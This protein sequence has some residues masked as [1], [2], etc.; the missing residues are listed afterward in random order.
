M[1]HPPPVYLSAPDTPDS[2]QGRTMAA[3]GSFFLPGPTEVLDDVLQAQARPMIGHRGKG[4]EDL[5]ARIQPALRRVF[6]HQG[7]VGSN[8]RPFVVAHVARVRFTGGGCAVHPLILPHPQV[9]NRL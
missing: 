8:E 3:F 5:L 7:Q 2:I 6:G 9:H 1:L 4:M